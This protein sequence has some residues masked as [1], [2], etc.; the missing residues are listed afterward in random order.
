MELWVFFQNKQ[1]PPFVLRTYKQPFFR[2][3]FKIIIQ[4]AAMVS[5][6]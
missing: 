2:I 6:Q 4:V 3:F 5:S 1:I